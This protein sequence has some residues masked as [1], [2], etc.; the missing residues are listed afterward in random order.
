VITRIQDA[1]GWALTFAEAQEEDSQDE[2]AHWVMVNRRAKKLRAKKKPPK[3]TPAQRRLSFA[4][5]TSPTAI[6]AGP[7]MRMSQFFLN[8]RTWN[9]SFHLRTGWTWVST[10]RIFRRLHLLHLLQDSTRRLQLCPVL[11]QVRRLLKQSSCHQDCKIL[12]CNQAHQK[13]LENWVLVPW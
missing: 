6:E 11:D 13:P 2:G 10:C 9:S 5:P 8:L 7:V 1:Q 4:D 12:I 3:Q